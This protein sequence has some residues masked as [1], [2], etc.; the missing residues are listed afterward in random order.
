MEDD[1]EATLT[2]ETMDGIS[3]HGM[4]SVRIVPSENKGNSQGKAKGK[5]EAPGQNKLPGERA[6]G[7][8]KG[9]NK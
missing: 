8:A 1:E 5:A 3:I 6:I 9:K 4:D 7:K 2:G